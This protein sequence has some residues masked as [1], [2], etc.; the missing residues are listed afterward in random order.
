MRVGRRATDRDPG[1]ASGDL[2]LGRLVFVPAPGQHASEIDLLILGAGADCGIKR[3]PDPGV[4]RQLGQQ[5][6]RLA[7]SRPGIKRVDEQLHA[8]VRVGDPV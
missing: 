8:G 4:A 5:R 6:E 7:L 2:S 1:S 3:G